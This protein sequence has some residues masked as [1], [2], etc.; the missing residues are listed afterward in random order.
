MAMQSKPMFRCRNCG[1]YGSMIRVNGGLKCGIKNC[2]W[3]HDGKTFKGEIIEYMSYD[4][5]FR[6]IGKVV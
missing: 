3:V 4:Q 6:D 1:F 5:F 2:G